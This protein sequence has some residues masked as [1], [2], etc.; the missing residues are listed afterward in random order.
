MQAERVRKRILSPDRVRLFVV[1]SFDR[2]SLRTRRISVGQTSLDASEECTTPF[3][4]VVVVVLV[5]K[6]IEYKSIMR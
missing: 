3:L 5:G 4:V 2:V 6:R 1:V